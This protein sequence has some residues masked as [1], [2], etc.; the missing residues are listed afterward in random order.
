MAAFASPRTG[1]SP[2]AVAVAALALAGICAMAWLA[3][4]SLRDDT[5]QLRL[6]DP[7]EPQNLI[8]FLPGSGC[9][10]AAKQ[11]AA[12]FVGLKGHWKIIAFEKP[13]VRRFQPFGCTSAFTAVADYDKLIERQARLARGALAAHREAP[14]K[15]LVGYSEGG[16]AAPAVAAAAPGFTHLV[17]A[18]AGGMDGD[19]LTYSLGASLSGPEKAARRIAAVEETPD[20]IDRFAW[21]DS[22]AYLSSLMRLRPLQFYAKLDLPILLIHGGRDRDVPPQSSEIAA[23]AFARA[24]KTNLTLAIEPGLDHRLGLDDRAAQTKLLAKLHAWLAPTP[25]SP[26]ECQNNTERCD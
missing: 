11:M 6:G 4:L 25:Q 16:L 1:V 10:P 3:T 13:G 12:F 19:A 14:L 24:G 5:A 2:L 18:S 21:D 17:V 26:A 7:R 15:V 23:A 9:E 20:A 22:Y 8:M